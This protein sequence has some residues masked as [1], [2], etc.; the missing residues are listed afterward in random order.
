M[1]IKSYKSDFPIF[2]TKLKGRPLIYLDSAATSQKPKVVIDL[3]KNFY[4]NSNANVKRGIYP[5]AEEA[6][7]VVEE[8]RERV[9]EFINAASKEEIIFTRNATEAINL[10]AYSMSHNISKKNIVST[11]V[12]E[13]HSNFVPW[14]MLSA[15]TSSLLYV[16]DIS[17]DFE[18]TIPSFREINVLAITH[19]SNVLGMMLDIEKIIR[20]AR[21]EN[22]DIIVIVD[23]AQS[24]CHLPVDV[25][26]IDCDF[27]AF[28]GHKVFAGM[29]V[30]VLY[31]KIKHLDNLDPFLFG[32]QMVSEVGIDKT[33]FRKAPDKFEA[34]TVSA[35]DIASLGM[36]INYI[37]GI[38]IKNILDHERELTRY[39]ISSLS[40]IDRLKLIGPVY[41]G[42]RLGIVSFV[43]EGVHS[44]D[45]AQVLG[46]MG[47]CVRAGHHCAMPLHKRL[48]ISSTVRA[49]LSV[50]NDEEDVDALVKGIKDTLKIFR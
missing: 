20:K 11:T 15:R 41:S 6:T 34:G 33:T 45:V 5:L 19:V 25:Q 42:K 4:E 13:H 43:L 7:A 9:K 38:G 36:A 27:L 50:Y 39:C 17:D 2:K 46:D 8:T 18:L 22:P 30:G 48:K 28:S 14:Q 3:I 12:L 40:K 47:I 49:S 24:V 29:G 1:K 44:H 16:L 10:V 35:A 31:G 23:A 37:Q 26:K 21:K 32:G